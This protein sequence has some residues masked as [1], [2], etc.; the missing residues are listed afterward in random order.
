[1]GVYGVVSFGVSR[2]RREM[3]IRMAVGASG[4][5]VV[6]EVVR[7]GLRPLLVGIVAGGAVA[8]FAV[9]SMEAL[10]YGVGLYDPLAYAT[11]VLIIGAVG[12][13]ACSIPALRAARTRPVE[14]LTEA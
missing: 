9:R 5:D 4:R 3:G 1:V 6:V 12:L 13:A 14:V 10:L 2:R 7:G 11:G 8:L